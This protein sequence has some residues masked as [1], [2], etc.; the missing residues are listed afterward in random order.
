MRSLKWQTCPEWDLKYFKQVD[1]G[2]TKMLLERVACEPLPCS[3]GRSSVCFW[4]RNKEE[5]KLFALKKQMNL[6]C[7]ICLRSNL[8][9]SLCINARKMPLHTHRVDD[10]IQRRKTLKTA[11][12]LKR[13]KHL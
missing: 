6:C 1:D 3:L 7:F 4:R 12:S 9:Y 11:F 13:R 8:C 10:E 5:T 2:Q